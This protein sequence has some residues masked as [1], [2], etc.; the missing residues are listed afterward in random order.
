MLYTFPEPAEK[1]FLANLVAPEQMCAQE[2]T[3]AILFL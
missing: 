2:T 3:R 1:T